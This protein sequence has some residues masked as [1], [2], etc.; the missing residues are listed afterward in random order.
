MVVLFEV[1]LQLGIIK[2]HDM[3]MKNIGVTMLVYASG[4][5]KNGLFLLVRVKNSNHTE[6]SLG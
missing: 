2:I 4:G 6:L 1:F 3:I 5:S